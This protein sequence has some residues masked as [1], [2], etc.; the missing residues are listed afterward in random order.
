MC[1]H[2]FA[3]S[4]RVYSIGNLTSYTNRSIYNKQIANRYIDIAIC[5]K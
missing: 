4:Y 3:I 5:V 1:K 2:N